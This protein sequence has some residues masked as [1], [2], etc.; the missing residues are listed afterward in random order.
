M[1]HGLIGL[2][3]VL[4]MSS[5]SWANEVS[6]SLDCP[7]HTYF[8]Q[9]INVIIYTTRTQDHRSNGSA[10]QVMGGAV[11]VAY[12]TAMA[13][14]APLALEDFG[15]VPG[16]PNEYP[17]QWSDPTDRGFPVLITVQ[18]PISLRPSGHVLPS[19]VTIT[20]YE[21]GLDAEQVPNGPT[22]V[23][24][25]GGCT[26]AVGH[27]EEQAATLRPRHQKGQRAIK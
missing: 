17:G 10:L 26:V 4:L 5:P 13:A 16:E 21:I 2:I 23:L 24:G 8:G 9:T 20:I 12:G 3:L 22:R 18:I 1:K 7:E 11:N 25:W 19:Y 14:Q 27:T 15:F 6:V